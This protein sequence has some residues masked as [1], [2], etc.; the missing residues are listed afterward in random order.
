MTGDKSIAVVIVAYN[1]ADTIEQTVRRA[2]DLPNCTTVVVVDNGLDGSGEIAASA[3]AVVLYRP[4]NPGFGTSHNAG[5]TLTQE[6]FVLL[7]NADAEVVPTG[8]A[9]GLD[10][11]VG[12][13]GVAATQGIVTSRRTGGPERSMGPDLRWIHLLGRALGIRSL[14]GTRAGRAA[15]RLVGVSDVIDRVPSSYAEVQT[16]AATAPLVRRSAFDDV[17]GFD[18]SFFLYGEDLDLCRRLRANGWR[19][20]GIPCAWANHADG[21]TADSPLQRELNWWSGTLR[22]AALW[23]TASCFRLAALSS[24]LMAVRLI[25]QHPYYARRIIGEL[26]IG[27]LAGRRVTSEAGVEAPD[28]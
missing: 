27:P 3:G 8:L 17:G 2:L 1:S 14:L 6:Q 4:E 11:L 19:L 9:A 26:L 22:Y 16:L 23:W 7:L 18:E 10:L 21:S 15:A 13:P 24:G 28:S 20:V 12:D 25:L 5:V